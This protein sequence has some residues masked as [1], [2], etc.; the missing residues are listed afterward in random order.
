MWGWTLL[1][2]TNIA[3]VKKLW[4]R[5]GAALCP[6]ANLEPEPTKGGLIS[7]KNSWFLISKKKVPNHTPL[8]IIHLKRN[9]SPFFGDSSQS[10]KFSEFKP[11]LPNGKCHFAFVEMDKN[12]TC[13]V[14][15]GLHFE[16]DMSTEQH[17]LAF[18]MFESLGLD[19]LITMQD[20]ETIEWFSWCCMM[21]TDA[22]LNFSPCKSKCLKLFSFFQV[23]FWSIP[24]SK[25]LT[26][27]WGSCLNLLKLGKGFST[28]GFNFVITK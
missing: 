9:L 8:S 27:F 1:L 12:C 5:K 3:N 10:V 13:L 14:N 16:F 26:N 11:P 4:I 23:N 22:Q 21:P 2:Q 20:R 25:W 6:D 17:T 24:L 18:V 7:E 15:N 28:S 19:Q